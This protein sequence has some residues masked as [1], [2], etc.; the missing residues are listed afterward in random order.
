MGVIQ[1]V[2]G[3]DADNDG[4]DERTLAH[5]EKLAERLIRR[6]P[7]SVVGE[8]WPWSELILA[9]TSRDV[10]VKSAL[11]NPDKTLEKGRI[12]VHESNLLQWPRV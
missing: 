5:V 3:S 8:I 4:V 7:L 9:G 12:A 6:S 11:Q 10:E 1:S 2:P